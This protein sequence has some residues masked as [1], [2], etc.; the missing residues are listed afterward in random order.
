M[1]ITVA[2]PDIKDWLSGADN[3]ENS[4]VYQAIIKHSYNEEEENRSLQTPYPLCW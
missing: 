3:I 1:N 4:Q 2:N